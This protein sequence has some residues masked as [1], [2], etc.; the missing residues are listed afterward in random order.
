MNPSA[1]TNLTVIY[2]PLPSYIASNSELGELGSSFA[3]KNL[4]KVDPNLG[5]SDSVDEPFDLSSDIL[6][7]DLEDIFTYLSFLSSYVPHCFEFNI[8]IKVILSI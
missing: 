8:A 1:N 7:E 4:F 3:K 2:V 5:T 6:C